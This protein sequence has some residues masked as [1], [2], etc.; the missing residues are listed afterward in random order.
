MAEGGKPPAPGAPPPTPGKEPFGGSS[1]SQAT[2]NAGYE[3][4]ALQR[5]GVIVKQVQ[6]LMNLVGATS[7]TGQGLLKALNILVK[8][9]PAGTVSP[10]AEK[11]ML[12]QAQMRNTQNMATA[13]QLKQQRMQPP[14]A[15]G[16]PGGAAPPPGGGM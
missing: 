1:A 10:N 2:P 15:G 13:Q 16:P 6:D 5:V 14:G 7:E 3:A 11:N 4:A 8:M 9:V 12:E